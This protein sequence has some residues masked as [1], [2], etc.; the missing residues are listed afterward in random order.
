VTSRSGIGSR[1]GAGAPCMP[2]TPSLQGLLTPDVLIG[3]GE[4]PAAPIGLILKRAYVVQSK[5]LVG[6]VQSQPPHATRRVQ[7]AYELGPDA[8]VALEEVA[9]VRVEFF[10]RPEVE[11]E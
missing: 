3:T 10:R 7:K 4:H 8:W 6:G 2:R 9:D 5:G 11:V 1:G